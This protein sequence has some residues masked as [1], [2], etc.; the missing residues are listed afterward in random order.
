MQWLLSRG[1]RDILREA[2]SSSA[3]FW[4]R[5]A[6][7]SALVYAGAGLLALIAAVATLPLYKPPGALDWLTNEV[8]ALIA[9]V[10]GAIMLFYLIYLWFLFVP[11]RNDRIVLALRAYVRDHVDPLD[12]QVRGLSDDQLRAKTAEFRKRLAAGESLD[13]LRPEA[14]AAV[15]EASR[16][17][18]NHRQFECQLIGGRVIE[19]CSIAEMRTGEGK[20]IVCYMAN[21]MKVLSG[22]KVHMITVND[23]LVKRDA[24]FCRPIFALLGVSVGYILSS[25]DSWGAGAGQRAEAYASDITYGTNS[26]FGFDYLRDNMKMWSRDQVQG[27]L[28]FAVV[29]EV[30]SILIDEARTP[31]IISGPAHDDVS[32][33]GVADRIAQT[34]IRRQHQSNK[35]M[36]GRIDA[37]EA[38]PPPEARDN[39]RFGTAVKKFR[40][41]PLLLSSEEA[42]AI[43][44]LQYYV[45]ELDR[46]SAHMTEHGAK[47]AQAE[48]GIGSFYDSRNMNWPHN[49][50]NA[51]RAHLC[52]QKDKDYVVQD[53]VVTIVDEFTGRL[54][55]GRQWSDG[56]HQAVE[57]KERV[58]VK[59]ENQTLATIT[60]QNYFRMYKQMAGM[61]GTAM[62][63]A[64]EFMKIYKLDVVTI[65]TNRPIRRIDSNDKIYK[66]LK[67][68]YDAII[69]EIRSIS[70]FGYPADPWTLHD[71]LVW[72]KKKSR[73]V[74]GDNADLKHV[75]ENAALI[76]EAL[77]AFKDGEGDEK[78]PERAYVKLMEGH[79]GGRPVLV[80]TTSVEN[81]ER[82]SKLL[83]QTYGIA[84]E[85]LNAKQ[86]AR[87]AE[88]IVKAGQQHEG[89]REGRKQMHGN[90]TIATNMAGRGTDIVLGPGVANIGGLHVLGT[91][92]HE[93][94]RIDNQ[95]RGRSGRQGDPGTSRFFLSMEDELLKLF[96][97]E[98]TLKMLE[99]MGFQEGMAIEHSMISR[100]IQNAQ[101]KVEERNFGIR[102]N[103]L[104][105]DEVMDHQ[106]RTFYEL[107]QRVVVGR[108]LSELI[109]EMI[110]Q[111]VAD[112]TDRYY[113]PRYSA[114][115][116]AEWVGQNI[117]TQIDQSRLDLHQFKDLCEQV[118]E[119]AGAEVKS[120]V[121]RT[122]GEYIDPD[123]DPEDW[124]IRGLISWAAQNGLTLT[125]R[126]V[127]DTDPQRLREMIAEAAVRKIESQ[128]LSG[129]EPFCDANYGK[130]R[131]TSWAHDKF[132]V[133]VPADELRGTVR[134]D[135][136]RI[137]SEKMR[138]A[139][140]KREIEYPAL[141]IIQ[142][143]MQRGGSNANEI[144]AQ[145]A[146]WVERK[147]GLNWTYEHFLDKTPAQIFQ[148]LRALNDDYLTNHKL[149]SEIDAALTAHKGPALLDW[150]KE[151]FGTVL[152]FVELDL[153]SPAV[154]EQLKRTAY[155][156]LR[157]ELTHIERMVVLT[158]VDAVWKDHMYSI[159]LLREAIGLRGYAEKD[160]K[161]EYKK[162]A[163]RIF[164]ETMSNIRE[165]VTDLIF[166]VQVTP[167]DVGDGG[168]APAEV[169]PS[170]PQAGS[171]YGPQLTARHD[172]ATNAGLRAGGQAAA[173]AENQAPA[174]ETI[175]RNM[176][177]VGR[178]DP[179]PCGSG[180]K[181]KQCH[182]KG[183][184]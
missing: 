148:E 82:L 44:H 118:R 122:F 183:A 177:R 75:G 181:F 98:W 54:M 168:D 128:D 129:L 156:M 39:P 100:N 84:H 48:L 99:K 87:E 130:S 73:S 36:A 172:D 66:T 17:A 155:E 49:L 133:V 18:R 159:S 102:K 46:K 103:L 179:C 149:D 138:A 143:A 9:S 96:M 45:V 119:Y 115:C 63:E 151:R 126:Q 124:D 91:E 184:A 157:F 13:A 141:A 28:D 56:L 4:H 182:G 139:Y 74:E 10:L 68:K 162:E 7:N 142:H 165:R 16:R 104:E 135:A 64:D 26:E 116:V 163:T 90:V 3:V 83:S 158:T 85:V 53:D 146:R 23:Y 175:R 121:D 33:Y 72:A 20:T 176:P 161:I 101:K 147:Y 153:N 152:E 150:A 127:R 14:Y 113:D 120:T 117:G 38:N 71:E 78:A 76:D 125:Q 88:I 81:S 21:Y 77:S 94:R 173:V 35:D 180:K 178:N 95:L 24:E 65:P 15:R 136:E 52:Y 105:Y 110:D 60:L 19:D 1:D 70:Q 86:H 57:S 11:S 145:I 114:I 97:P 140:R 62:T 108:G 132:G 134:E 80:G 29:D 50:D 27:R 106:R 2:T 92:R 144:Y 89:L 170:G 109:W 41:D 5:A 34:L 58:T 37:L 67:S 55:T 40:A 123:T 6:G 47:L 137:F 42:D 22:L 154:G 43:G 69:E 79:L 131:L 30:D 112:A 174:A 171:T 111:S 166:K 167:P 8:V 32:K 61:T 160:P 51:L 31:L 169:E 164:N 107:R 25:M 59:Q 12:E 93:S